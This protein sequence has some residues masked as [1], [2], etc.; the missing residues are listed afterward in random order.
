M[1][2]GADMTRCKMTS[3]T[4]L[5]TQRW[6]PTTRKNLHISV[7][8]Q[9]SLGYHYPHCRHLFKNYGKKCV[10]FFELY[11]ISLGSFK[12]VRLTDHLIT[13]GKAKKTRKFAAVKRMISP[14]DIRM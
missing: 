10:S 11:I 8:A 5:T 13:Q 14:K 12:V 6:F 1:K 7:G 3:D 4:E 9:A 2:N